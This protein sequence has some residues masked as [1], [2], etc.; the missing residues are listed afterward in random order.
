PYRSLNPRRTVGQSIVEGPMNYGVPRIEATERARELVE[1]VGIAASALGRYPHQFSGG[2]RQR[3]CI[4]RALAMEP[5][6]LIADE[7]VSALDVSVQAQVMALLEDIR[8]R[9]NLAMLFIT[10]DLRVAARLCD[11]IAVMQKGR[12]VEHGLTAQIFAE[13]RHEYTRELFAAIPGR[14][15]WGAASDVRNHA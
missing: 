9:F 2:Q 15:R 6:I 3:L 12:V 4:A 1:T 14:H 7:A 8:D 5:E 10:H 13:P 11:R